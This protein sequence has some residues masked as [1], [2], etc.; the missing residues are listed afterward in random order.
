M[1]EEALIVCICLSHTQSIVVVVVVVINVGL[2]VQLS[3]KQKFI[4]VYMYKNRVYMLNILTIF[5]M[6]TMAKHSF[7]DNNGQDEWFQAQN[8]SKYRVLSE[9]WA[10]LNQIEL[11]IWTS[12]FEPSAHLA[13]DSTTKSKCKFS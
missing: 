12:Y 3:V 13:S 7:A 10:K 11:K 8:V 2:N 1:N 4:Y 5:E 9:S 6:T